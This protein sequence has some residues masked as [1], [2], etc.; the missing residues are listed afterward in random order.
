MSSPKLRMQPADWAALV[1]LSLLWGGAFFFAKVAVGVLPPLLVVLARVALAMVCLWAV[2]L[3]TGVRIALQP[4]LQLALLVLGFLNNIVPFGLLFW[5]QTHIASGLAS[6]LNATTP[7]FTV[8]LAHAFTGD[9][10]LTPSRLIGI[11]LGV[12]G[13]A[14]LLGPQ[15]LQGLGDSEALPAQLACL[16][17]A[18]SYGCA[19]I[20]GRRYVRGLPPLAVAT[21]QVTASTLLLAPVVLVLTPPWAV[22]TPEA[23]PLA[24][25][26]AL[27]TVS[28]ALAYV[29]FFRVLA[30]AGATNVSLVTLLVPV[31]AV[32]L[33]AVILGER[34]DGRELAGMAVIGLGLLALDGRILGRLR[35]RRPVSV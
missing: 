14:T 9:D 30:R 20:W 4:R 7:L 1:F 11:A 3:F 29:L 21:G 17:A 25:V 8:L 22:P 13:V 35:R 18:F 15:A 34:L 27:G 6:I 19:A 16:G 5:A 32:L 23:A 33:G 26:L 12:V 24:A 31:S 10:R 28:T 2:M